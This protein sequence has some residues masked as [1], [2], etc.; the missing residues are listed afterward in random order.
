MA[1]EGEAGRLWYHARRCPWAFFDNVSKYVVRANFIGI[2]KLLTRLLSPLGSYAI[3]LLVDWCLVK[4][5][6]RGNKSTNNWAT[7]QDGGLRRFGLLLLYLFIS[8]A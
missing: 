1:T 3:E 7:G 4:R 8:D 6:E 2:P 5:W